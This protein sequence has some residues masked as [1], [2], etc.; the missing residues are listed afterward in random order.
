MRREKK[1]SSEERVGK[2][3]FTRQNVQCVL[4]LETKVKGRMLRPTSHVVLR[5]F[6][7]F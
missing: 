1:K 6:L 4:P 7:R 2:V 3:K 5:R